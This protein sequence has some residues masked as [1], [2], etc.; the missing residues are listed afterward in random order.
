MND[1]AQVLDLLHTLDRLPA[2]DHLEFPEGFDYPLA[3]A[4]AIRLKD[5]LDE[6]FGHPCKLDDQI[7]DASYYFKI[8]LLAE[9]TEA[10]IP[11]GVRLSNY[12]NLAVV[13]TPM[14]DSHDDLD[15]AVRGGAL[16]VADRGRIEAA[17]TEF[18]YTLIPPTAPA[19]ALRRRDGPCRGRAL[20][21]RLRPVPRTRDL[22]DPLF[23]ALVTRHVHGC[24]YV[25]AG[26]G[27]SGRANP[28][29]GVTQPSGRSRG[30]TIAVPE[31]WPS[32]TVITGSRRP[33]VT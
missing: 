7:Q 1:D 6:A 27:R 18:G 4:R 32:S 3:R 30:T 31:P 19:P 11:V 9:A 15:Q 17:L 33:S 14:P 10:R 22:V 5:R 21:R 8:T 20:L 2:P 16:S 12:G 26:A 24:L 23:R 13:T 29:F 28:F 25:N